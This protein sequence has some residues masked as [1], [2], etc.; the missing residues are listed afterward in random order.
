MEHHIPARN[1]RVDHHVRARRRRL[2]RLRESS[3]YDQRHAENQTHAYS[4]IHHCFSSSLPNIQNFFVPLYCC[5]RRTA[6]GSPSS[7][8]SKSTWIHSPARSSFTG[9]PSAPSAP[10]CMR[11]RTI[12]ASSVSVTKAPGRNVKPL[13]SLSATS[14]SEPP[15][16][17]ETGRGIPFGTTAGIWRFPPAAELFSCV[18]FTGGTE[19]TWL[20]VSS[21]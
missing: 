1:A 21:S 20:V 3:A 7:P 6:C 12:A 9:R 5:G 10:R 16:P 18:L 19:F 17:A 2:L 15:A 4:G 8:T 13:N 14:V 11:T